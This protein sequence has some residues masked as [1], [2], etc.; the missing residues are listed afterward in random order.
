[1]QLGQDFHCDAV[2]IC[3]LLW[4]LYFNIVSIILVNSSLY[5]YMYIY[6]DYFVTGATTFWSVKGELML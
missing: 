3:R 1:M 5:V 4:K 6:N 2:A